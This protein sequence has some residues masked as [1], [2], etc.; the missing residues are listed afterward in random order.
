MK[1]RER[2]RE[3]KRERREEKRVEASLEHMERRGE[4]K[5]GKNKRG[6]G[7]QEPILCP[8]VYYLFYC[9]C[10]YWGRDVLWPPMEVRTVRELV[11]SQH[12]VC[13]DQM[14]VVRLGGK[15][16]CLWSHYSSLNLLSWM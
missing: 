4:G 8:L 5:S 13:R 7:A 16:F 14:Q 6:A 2:E 11:L 10:L 12:A 3:E 9:V 1:G 15:H